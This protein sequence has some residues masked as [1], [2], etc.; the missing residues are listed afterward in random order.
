M[1]PS[2]YIKQLGAIYV[3]T[4]GTGWAFMATTMT[5]AGIGF[6]AVALDGALNFKRNQILLMS[7]ILFGKNVW[8]N[9]ELLI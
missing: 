2:D 7:G 5:G 4:A 1:M 6:G 3:L 8:R 9:R